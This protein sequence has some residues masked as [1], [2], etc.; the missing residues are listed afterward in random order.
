MTKKLFKK[1]WLFLIKKGSGKPGCSVMNLPKA[2]T[3]S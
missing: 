1:V 2:L 3:F